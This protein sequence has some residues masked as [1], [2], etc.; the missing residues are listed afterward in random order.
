MH[1]R[2][3]PLPIL[4]YSHAVS[5]HL[6][7]FLFKGNEIQKSTWMTRSYY[8]RLKD[9][10]ALAEDKAGP[11]TSGLIW[12]QGVPHLWIYQIN[13]LWNGRL[14]KQT[15]YKGPHHSWSELNPCTK[16]VGIIEGKENDQSRTI[17]NNILLIAWIMP[18]YYHLKFS[19]SH[20]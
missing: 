7:L 19:H 1:Y 20:N 13:G 15:I 4:Q 18:N 6:K 17:S 14:C 11:Y 8:Y 2:P 3:G 10:T 5:V 12:G 9:K 16:K